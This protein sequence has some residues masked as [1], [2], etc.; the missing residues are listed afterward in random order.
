[1]KAIEEAEGAVE[2]QEERVKKL[3]ELAKNTKDDLQQKEQEHEEAVAAENGHGAQLV[4]DVEAT[5]E[6]FITETIEKHP[7][8]YYMLVLSGQGSGAV[9][10]FLTENSRLFGQSIPDL[11]KTLTAIQEKKPDFRIH[12]L[13]LD[14]C[15]M[16]MAEVAYEVR[17]YVDY[18]VGAE[19]F[20]PNT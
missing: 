17:N 1:K 7:A 16:G 18:L 6:N 15:L 12:I 13:G 14:S 4:D 20:T 2:Q 5:L 19:G 8:T 3:E 10:D 11:K 9:G